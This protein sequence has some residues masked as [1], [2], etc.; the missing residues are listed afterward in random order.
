[1]KL[2][3]VPPSMALEALLVPDDLTDSNSDGIDGGG[4]GSNFIFLFSV[5]TLLARPS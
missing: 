5:F 4:T 3:P 1:M 2:Q